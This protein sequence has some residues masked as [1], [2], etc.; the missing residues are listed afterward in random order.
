[1]SAL[2]PAQQQRQSMRD[3]NGRYAEGSTA[4]AETDGVQLAAAT[5]PGHDP[6]SDEFDEHR[7]GRIK[8][9][10]EGSYVPGHG[11]G[12]VNH[13]YPHGAGIVFASCEGHGGF[14]LSKQ[15]NQAIPAPLRN[16]DGWYEED[17]EAYIVGA[18]HPIAFSHA[19][20]PTAA[21]LDDNRRTCEQ[22]LRD[23]FPDQWTE[24]TGEECTTDNSFTMRSRASDQAR[25]EWQQ[26]VAHEFVI[27]PSRLPDVAGLD[28]WNP[29][30]VIRRSDNTS[31]TIMIPA[32]H[33]TETVPSRDKPLTPVDLDRCVDVTDIMDDTAPPAD[34]DPVHDCPV[35]WN[36]L[37]PRQ[38][39]QV[40]EQMATLYRD[41]DDRIVRF[42]TYL[43]EQGLCG[44]K[45]YVDA[46]SGRADHYLV[47]GN[48]QMI[49]VPAATW[50]AVEVPDMDSATNRAD[51]EMKRARAGLERAYASASRDALDRA[52]Q[53]LRDAQREVERVNEEQAAERRERHQ[54]RWEAVAQRVREHRN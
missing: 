16:S 29:V 21:E 48:R 54:R 18:Y 2:T 40:S 42:D 35:N 10:A 11:W 53:R 46:R 14:K 34:P 3:Q 23:W 47:V 5:Q 15:R 7:W 25:L 33:Y 30:T 12:R 52:K 1:M 50:K 26:A 37:T 6:V 19:E 22:G 38:Q 17:C 27:D 8:G 39:E 9:P 32:D 36:A 49:Q 31:R 28:G 43:T 20:T 41:D 44:K 24:L 4:S 51:N 45:Q 13:V